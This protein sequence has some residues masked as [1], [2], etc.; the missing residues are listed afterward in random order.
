M[1]RVNIRQTILT[2]LAATPKALSASEIWRVA[3][4]DPISVS[5]TVINLYAD[6]LLL[7]VG[8]SKPWRY[9]H[10]CH[11]QSTDRLPRPTLPAAGTHT[12][13]GLVCG[14]TA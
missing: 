7:R 8:N 9:Q 12:P 2:T 13:F 10:P 11:A 5:A 6:G 3:G 14:V 4:L 1:D